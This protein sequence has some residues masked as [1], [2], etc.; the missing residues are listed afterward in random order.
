M[1]RDKNLRR[2]ILRRGSGASNGPGS[3]KGLVCPRPVEPVDDG[4]ALREMSGWT[5]GAALRELGVGYLLG[6]SFEF[7]LRKMGS[8]PRVLGRGAI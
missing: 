4:E 2:N 3:G 8:Q 1:N 7:I 6:E 5:T